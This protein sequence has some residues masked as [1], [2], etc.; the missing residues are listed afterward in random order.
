MVNSAC[1]LVEGDESSDKYLV[2]YIVPKG[3]FSHKDVLGALQKSLPSHMIPSKV[4]FIDR[5]VIQICGCGIIW[6][7]QVVCL[8][9]PLFSSVNSAKMAEIQNQN[10][11]NR[12]RYRAFRTV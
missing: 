10:K 2:A 1:V 6:R 7:L 9:I 11:R 8:C 3:K 5:Q 4:V 12:W